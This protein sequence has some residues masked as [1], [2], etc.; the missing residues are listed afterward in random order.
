MNISY[1][2]FIISKIC[3][4]MDIRICFCMIRV[5]YF[6]L[7]MYIIYLNNIF[8]IVI[9]K[10]NRVILRNIFEGWMIS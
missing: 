4:I 8:F 7:L 3:E 6:F 5:I 2:Y 10:R 9:K 1:M